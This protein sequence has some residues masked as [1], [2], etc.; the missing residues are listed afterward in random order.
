MSES[1]AVG[2][3]CLVH[4]F[5]LFSSIPYNKDLGA[6]R[7]EQVVYALGTGIIGLLLQQALV[8]VNLLLLLLLYDCLQHHY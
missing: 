7:P 3:P 5:K 2:H 6:N 4:F 8:L 1:V